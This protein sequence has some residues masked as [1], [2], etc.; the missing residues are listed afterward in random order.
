MVRVS[1]WVDFQ[2]AASRIQ[3]GSSGE[4]EGHV[5]IGNLLALAQAH[6]LAQVGCQDVLTLK[7]TRPLENTQRG[8]K[9][10]NKQF[11]LLFN[12]NTYL[13]W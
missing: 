10:K 13:Y 3:L 9:N 1:V 12:D 8:E 11:F 6:G 5:P 4:D 7:K 2:C